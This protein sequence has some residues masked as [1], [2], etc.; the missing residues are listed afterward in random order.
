[1]KYITIV[2]L[3]RI[4]QQPVRKKFNKYLYRISLLYEKRIDAAEC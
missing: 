3:R 4:W 2:F 1:M